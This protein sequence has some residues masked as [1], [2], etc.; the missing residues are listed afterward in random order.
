MR[1]PRARRFWLR[2]FPWR[3]VL[4]LSVTAEGVE[5]AAQAQWLQ[6]MGCD[7]AQG[8]YFGRPAGPVKIEETIA[9]AGRA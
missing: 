1:T 9:A 2:S 8:W 4:G 7:S 5:S 3:H 6:A